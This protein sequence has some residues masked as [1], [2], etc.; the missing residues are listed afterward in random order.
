[1]S[2]GENLDATERPVIAATRTTKR[3]GPRR[4]RGRRNPP[5]TEKRRH[6]WQKFVAYA[7]GFSATDREK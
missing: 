3:R 6:D 7:S 4:S 1:M 2:G 5:R